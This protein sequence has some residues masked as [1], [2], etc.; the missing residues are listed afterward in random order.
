MA[1]RNLLACLALDSRVFA[2]HCLAPGKEYRKCAHREEARK[3]AARE[4]VW[5]GR[6]AGATD[7]VAS[8]LEHSVS[9]MLPSPELVRS[10]DRSWK[11]LLVRS[12]IISV[13]ELQEKGRNVACYSLTD[14]GELLA[15]PLAD[16]VIHF[17]ATARKL[18][19]HTFDSM[20]KILGHPDRVLKVFNIAKWLVENGTSTGT[21][22]NIM[23]GGKSTLTSSE[24][25]NFSA[26]LRDMRQAGLIDVF[27]YTQKQYKIADSGIGFLGK[28]QDSLYRE[29]RTQV[30][31]QWF[32]QDVFERV[33]DY[34]AD[35]PDATYNTK[36][37]TDYIHSAL[38]KG[39]AEVPRHLKA[40]VRLSLRSLEGLGMLKLANWPDNPNAESLLRRGRKTKRDQSVVVANDM[41][42]L[43]YEIVLK[44]AEMAAL[45]VPERMEHYQVSRDE[46]KEFVRNMDEE[47]SQKGI[48]RSESILER[49]ERLIRTRTR[50]APEHAARLSEMQHTLGSYGITLSSDSLLGILNALRKE[51]RIVHVGRGYYAVPERLLRTR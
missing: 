49:V 20:E 27:S 36:E 13:R 26:T 43:F 30:P 12:G 8:F 51:G 19:G 1:L 31:D 4:V 41:T 37:I 45:L 24:R 16:C 48:K 46:E 5:K 38:K 3:N 42:K 14:A 34:I 25:G 2:L 11:T 35:K 40:A 28:D 10:G 33:V 29:A 23:F 9:G 21:D 32:S 50:Y 15:K 7:R 39:G 47:K 18:P 17:V 6:V 22:L 44:N